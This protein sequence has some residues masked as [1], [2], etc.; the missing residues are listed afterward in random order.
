MTVRS[1]TIRRHRKS[2]HPEL[3]LTS[4]KKLKTGFKSW[5]EQC[6]T[7]SLEDLLQDSEWYFFFLLH[8][9]ARF[10]ICLHRLTR[11]RGCLWAREKPIITVLGKLHWSIKHVPKLSS[12][13]LSLWVLIIKTKL[14]FC[15]WNEM[16]NWITN[17]IYGSS[18]FPDNSYTKIYIGFFLKSLFL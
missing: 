4:N 10:F 7:K 3:S 15:E 6:T 18:F 5:R 17:H 1:Y 14:K 8:F 16:K 12:F 11:I 2:L 9:S 13:Y